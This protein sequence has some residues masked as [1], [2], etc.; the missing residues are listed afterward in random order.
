MAPKL[1][2]NSWLSVTVILKQK[3]ALQALPLIFGGHLKNVAGIFHLKILKFR[4]FRFLSK[5]KMAIGFL[6]FIFGFRIFA[7]H[8]LLYVYFGGYNQSSYQA[9]KGFSQGGRIH[10]PSFLFVKR[11][12]D[13]LG[14]RNL[15]SINLV[16]L[17]VVKFRNNNTSKP[18][19][20][21]TIIFLQSLSTSVYKEK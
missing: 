13:L 11:C 15:Y 19:G 3:L 2:D 12:L 4:F 1:S 14:L 10:P 6:V 5:M 21:R 17:F 16:S 9:K 20:Y 18:L 7:C 8:P